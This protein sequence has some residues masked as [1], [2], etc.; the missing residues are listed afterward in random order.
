MKKDLRDVKKNYSAPRLTDIKE[1][2]TEIKIDT[3]VMIP[4]EEVI[5]SI[6]ND[7]YIK[8]TSLR[9][10]QASNG[11]IPTIKDGDYL[12]GQ[13]EMTTQDTL[14]V[15]TTEGNYLYI[16]VHTIFDIKWKDMGKHI[17]NLIEISPEEKIV[18]AIPVY[19][20]END[21]NIILVTKN[22]M[23][24]RSKVSEFK[25][26]RYSKPANCMKLKDDDMV[27]DAIL[28]TENTVFLTTNTGYGLSFLTSEIPIVGVKASG[29]KAM[30]LKDD[31]LVSINNFDYEK[32]EFISIITD[33]GTAKRVRLNEFP[34]ST[35]ARR[36][37]LVLR[38]V[39]TNPYSVIKSFIV[40][41]K[42][43]IGIKNGDIN[44]LKV[45]ELSILDRYSTGSQISKH[46]IEDAFVVSELITK[47]DINN[48]EQKIEKEIPKKEKVSLEEIDDR[49]MT[50]DDFLDMQ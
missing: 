43:H 12:I 37:L 6:T 49:L 31:Y 25:L 33:K 16:P 48:I 19:S 32:Q 21:N 38:E 27:I 17:S 26:S 46:M 39:K 3:T 40:D 5:V 28:E 45:T 50:I 20:F 9:S 42:N 15:F 13:Y 11:E 36:G 1:E 14:L 41:N 34:I 8:R 23:I 29:V 44:I 18:S 47:E 2:I 30:K 10:Y 4:K 35:R 7:G 22:G 24:K